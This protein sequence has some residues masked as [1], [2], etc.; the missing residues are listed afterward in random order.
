M[1]PYKQLKDEYCDCGVIGSGIGGLTAAG[2]LA[3]EA[4]KK[5]LVL[6]WH[7]SAGGYTQS[8]NRPSYCRGANRR[9]LDC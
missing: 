6:E 3:K 2:L 9:N 1:I 5:L 4:G 8:F 7:Y